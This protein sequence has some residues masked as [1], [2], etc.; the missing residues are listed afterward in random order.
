MRIGVVGCGRIAQTFHLPF[1]SDMKNIEIGALCDVSKELV[2]RLGKKYNVPRIYTDYTRLIADGEVD[3]IINSTP[4]PFHKD[5]S[6]AA[7]ES[8]LDV[9]VEKPIALAASDA[10]EMIA[11]AKRKSRILMVGYMK[12]YDP[13]MKFALQ[14][15]QEDCHYIRVH[16]FFGL[17]DTIRS[18]IYELEMGDIPEEQKKQAS[19]LLNTQ[20]TQQ[21]G[22]VDSRLMSLY[23]Y[24]LG[25]CCHDTNMLRT[26][27]GDPLRVLKTEIWGNNVSE[28][29][30]SSPSVL[31]ILEF[32]DNI[33]CAFE[34]S[35]CKQ[36]FWDEAIVSFSP[37]K[38]V[39]LRWPNPYLKNS[40][41][42]LRVIK[43]KDVISHTIVTGNYESSYKRELAEFVTCVEKRKQPTTSGPDAKR[44]IEV[45]T[46]ILKSYMENRSINL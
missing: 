42:E 39:E 31:S 29:G 37:T 8:G 11:V 45:I 2:S 35:L 1:L 9:L 44:D 20:V 32:G 5:V 6:I 40:P 18:E 27:F 24:M 17:M 16:N 22:E 4:D 43:G 41:T 46:A 23:Q 7:M 25:I 26:I 13:I 12:R 38:I 15:F 36:R 34:F 19:L 14:E 28:A 3:A 10:E 21:I 30:F 33:R